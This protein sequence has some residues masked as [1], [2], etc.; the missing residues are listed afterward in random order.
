MAVQSNES[1]ILSE[2][3]SGAIAANL[4][5][6]YSS[7]KTAVAGAAERSIGHQTRESFADGDEITV[8]RHGALGT[9]IGVASAAISAGAD[10]YQAAGGKLG[11]TAT[12]HYRGVARTAAAA[13]GDWFEYIPLPRAEDE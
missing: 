3:A 9:H 5:V 13:D 11:T 12:G 4:I 1:G 8:T 10:V 7:G 2:T 6:K